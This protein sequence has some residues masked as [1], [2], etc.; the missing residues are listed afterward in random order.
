LKL[1]V[2]ELAIIEAA[3]GYWLP[4]QRWSEPAKLLLSMIPSG[5]HLLEDEPPVKLLE[6]AQTLQCR[7]TNELDNIEMAEDVVGWREGR[8]RW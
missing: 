3:L 5:Y 6:L 2:D 1:T 7:V 8:W 4:N